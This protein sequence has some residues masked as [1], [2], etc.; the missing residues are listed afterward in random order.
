M[1]ADLRIFRS[2]T[3]LSN[4]TGENERNCSRLIGRD[5]TPRMLFQR[6]QMCRRRILSRWLKWSDAGD[7]KLS[8]R[9]AQH[10]ERGGSNMKDREA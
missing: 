2:L 1:S 4:E 10:L 3:Q 7:V 9:I 6:M 8:H 5:D